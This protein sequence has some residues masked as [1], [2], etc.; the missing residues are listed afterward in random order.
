MA[1]EMS[2][3]FNGDYVEVRSVGDKSYQTAVALWTEIVRVCAEHRCYKVLGI[4][5]STTAMPIM[6]AVRHE[7]LFRDFAITRDYRIAWVELNQAAVGNVKF[8]ENFLLNRS[9]IN[10]KL[11]HD[12]DQARE[13]LLNS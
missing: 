13:W 5:R 4:A 11:F 6:D 12:V 9:L 3:T 10:G 7:Q 1:Y 2:V 8:L